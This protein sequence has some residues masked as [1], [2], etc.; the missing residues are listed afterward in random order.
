MSRV[1]RGI[2]LL[3]GLA[4]SPAWAEVTTVPNV[5]LQRYLGKW[6]EVASIPQ[7]FQ[8]KCTGNATAE[9]SSA[10]GSLIKVLNSCD[11]ADGG[12]MAAEG[13]GKVVDPQSNSKLK[14]TFVKII[15]WIFAFGGDYWIVDLAPDYSY[16]LVGDPSAKF[17]WI[18]SRTQAPAL[19]L[20]RKAEGKFRAEGY[21]TCLILT[22]VQ[23][24]GNSSRMPLCDFVK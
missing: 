24:G 1:L 13:R 6:Y 7:R 23:E 14:V 17:A 3:T 11:T 10:E 2:F 16:A 21:D 9:Y 8:S 5:D 20:Y 12:R 4:A 15:D 22:S 18:L 19:D